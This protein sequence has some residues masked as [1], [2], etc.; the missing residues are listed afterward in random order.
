M[1]RL[2]GLEHFPSRIRF[3]LPHHKPVR[4]PL[5]CLSCGCS[6]WP[7]I[8]L[9]SRWNKTNIRSAV[10]FLDR[11]SNYFQLQLRLQPLRKY[12]NCFWLENEV[13]HRRH[14][15]EKRG[16]QETFWDPN[17]FHFIGLWSHN[18]LKITQ[19]R[20]KIGPSAGVRGN[21]LV[22]GGRHVGS[23][24]QTLLAAWIFYVI[25]ESKKSTNDI[26]RLYHS[27]CPILWIAIWKAHER[28]DV[29]LCLKFTIQLHGDM[30]VHPRGHVGSWS[31]LSI[32]THINTNCSALYRHWTHHSQRPLQPTS[33]S[34][35]STGSE[36]SSNIRLMSH[37]NL[38]PYDLTDDFTWM[39]LL[40]KH[41]FS[42]I[43]RLTLF[44]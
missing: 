31:K 6:S 8:W 26:G 29:A 42:R 12:R 40:C 7:G 19:K 41:V 24:L 35:R 37:K 13:W 5:A 18:T 17:R 30:G 34:A 9:Q 23:V 16:A 22:L 43:T 11:I 36:K 3:F 15:H 33:E 28:K 20:L 25:S 39:M 32:K 10:F 44:S 14:L 2:I 4:R 1:D 38:W 21:Q 27:H